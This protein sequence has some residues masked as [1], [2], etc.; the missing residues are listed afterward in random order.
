M[1]HIGL[2]LLIK[3]IL[4]TAT[5]VIK[6]VVNN[7]TNNNNNNNLSSSYTWIGRGMLDNMR[8]VKIDT[9]NV[10]VFRSDQ[11]KG[12]P[13]TTTNIHKCV[14]AFKAIIG[15]QDLLNNDSAK[16]YHCLIQNKIEPCV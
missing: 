16:V 1:L 2:N 3:K 5:N 10:R 4:I 15:F 13:Q 14:N 7:N 11:A 6:N 8:Q 12:D 9:L